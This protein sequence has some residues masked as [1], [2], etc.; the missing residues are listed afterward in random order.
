MKY[1]KVKTISEQDSAIRKAAAEL[2]E[3]S[4]K[5]NYML[6]TV[7]QKDIE[8]LIDAL[9]PVEKVEPMDNYSAIKSVYE[10]KGRRRAI[11]L[12]RNIYGTPLAHA[13]SQV[14]GIAETDDWMYPAEKKEAV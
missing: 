5:Y 12:Y 14:D 10:T 7:R 2:I 9:Y 1:S 4:R 8:N 13:M 6:S 11:A 3:N